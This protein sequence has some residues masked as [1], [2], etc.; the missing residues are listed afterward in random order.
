MSKT[1]L[2]F[3]FLIFPLQKVSAEAVL[4]SVHW[5]KSVR[6]G[7]APVYRDVAQW[8]LPARGGFLNVPRAVVELK[9]LSDSPDEAVLLR[10][11]F[12]V[13]LTREGWKEGQ[14]TLPIILEERRVPTIRAQETRAVPLLINRAL[15]AAHLKRMAR[16]GLQPDLLRVQVAVEPRPGE[17]PFDGRI[18]EGMLPVVRQS[19]SGARP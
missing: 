4:G 14:W 2:L 13:R 12:S 19:V 17:K 18:L 9:N 16:A 11:A 6:R 10:Y 5:Q 1:A 3:V 15:L 7:P 8:I